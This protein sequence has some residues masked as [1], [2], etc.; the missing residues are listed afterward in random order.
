MN[1]QNITLAI[2]EE[3]LRKARRLAVER[4]TS[5]SALVT[6]LIANLVDDDERYREA[7]D[8]QL[9]LLDQ[10]LELGTQ[11]ATTWTLAVLH[12]R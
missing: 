11:G 9:A 3:V 12:A 2:P 5:L 6:Q 10:G 7:R 1:T 4:N 8:R